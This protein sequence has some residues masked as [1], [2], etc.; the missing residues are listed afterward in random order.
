MADAEREPVEVR[1]GSLIV[2]KMSNVSDLSRL[3]SSIKPTHPQPRTFMPDGKLI[4]KLVSIK[5]SA[6]W[7]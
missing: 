2:A 7:G 5:S 4:I 3:W 6:P 1:M